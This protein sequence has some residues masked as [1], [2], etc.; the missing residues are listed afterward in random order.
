MSC[1]GCLGRQIDREG[2]Q[3]RCKR[4][5]SI[6]S[7]RLKICS[8]DTCQGLGIQERFLK[9][10]MSSKQWWTGSILCIMAH[11]KG[12]LRP[13]I[14]FI[15]RRSMPSSNAHTRGPKS[16]FLH[17]GLNSRAEASTGTRIILSYSD[18]L[19]AVTLYQGIEIIN[20]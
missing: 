12:P 10:V 2:K 19:I 8:I 17:I 20:K 11:T 7:K 1:K 4:M 18:S 14:S 16:A 15:S 9:L 6:G 13:N 3:Q 5:G